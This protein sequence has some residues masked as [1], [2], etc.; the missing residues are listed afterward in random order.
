MLTFWGF[1]LQ[2]YAISIFEWS[3]RAG[4]L[5]ESA[6]MGTSP[7]PPA[8]LPVPGN[9][10]PLC[11][12]RRTRARPSKKDYLVLY[13]GMMGSRLADLWMLDLG[14][15]ALEYMTSGQLFE[16]EA[17]YP[18]IDWL[19]DWSF[20]LKDSVHWFDWL[21]A[22]VIWA[23]LNVCSFFNFNDTTPCLIFFLG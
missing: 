7:K 3:V 6:S 20:W 21:I 4:H 14:E 12:G 22:W 2:I 16:I 9:R 1:L 5:E 8:L 18:S 23:F 15:L 19:I 17:Q 11:C 10:I 13:G